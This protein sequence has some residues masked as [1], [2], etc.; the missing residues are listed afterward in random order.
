MLVQDGSVN[1]TGVEGGI[2][3]D[4]TWSVLGVGGVN[5]EQSGQRGEV[6]IGVRIARFGQDQT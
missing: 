3:V 1:M 2:G 6:G 4:V 5:T